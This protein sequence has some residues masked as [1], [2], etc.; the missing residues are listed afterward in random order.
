MDQPE[1]E[2]RFD[3][4][5]VISPKKEKDKPNIPST[6]STKLPFPLKSTKAP[7]K[8]LENVSSPTKLKTAEHNTM[9][10]KQ[11]PQYSVKYV[12]ENEKG[13]IGVSTVR[14]TIPTATSSGPRSPPVRT[15]RQK[16]TAICSNFTLTTTT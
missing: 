10:H 12:G 3:I 9:S 8:S 5:V 15:T 7:N 4:A 6:N 13:L 11:S 1:L 14:S 2:S 16:G